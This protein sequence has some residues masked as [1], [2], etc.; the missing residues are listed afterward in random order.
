MVERQ[1]WRTVED[2]L[3]GL[4]APGRDEPR[5]EPEHPGESRR[6]FLK[7]MGFGVSAAALAGCT[8]IPERQAIPLLSQPEGLLPG[9]ES[10]YATTCGGCP[11]GCGVLAKVRDGRPIKIEGNPRSP[12]SQGATCAVGQA[13]V[14]SLYDEHRLRGPLLAGQPASWA[15]VD[16]WV[17]PRLAAIAE[18]AES[19][20]GLA[21]LTGTLV[22][23]S[24]RALAADFVR[25]F[26]NARHAVHDAVSLAALR[27][28]NRQSFGRP[29]IPH[30]RFDRARVIVGIEADFLG[31]WLS[32]VEHARAYAEGRRPESP[33]GMMRHYQFESGLSLTG[34]NADRRAGLLPSE[35]GLVALA[36]V[37]RVA[38]RAGATVAMVET[39]APDP[40]CD[41][42]LLDRVA[43]DLW[44][45]RGES[46]VVCGVN[47]P[48][49][50]VAVNHLNGLLGNV[51]RTVD[52]DNPSWQRQGD[53]GAVAALI[54]AMERG[55]V[56]GLLLWGVNPAYDHP[57]AERFVRALGNVALK[58]SLAETLDE[59]AALADAVCP[60]HNFLE[61]WGDA[62]PVAGHFGLRQPAIAPLFDTRAAHESLLRWQGEPADPRA[63]L[64]S[65]WQRELFP[66]QDRWPTFDDFWDHAL[67]EGGCE[68][69]PASG[70]PAA[71]PR[72]PGGL[73]AAAAAIVAESRRAQEV[74]SQGGYEV[75]LYEKVSLR[76]GR[77]ANNPWLQELPDPVSRITWGNYA[78][79]APSLALELALREGDVVA[80]RG[81][82]AA[83]ELPVH[84]QPGQPHHAISVA[85][86]YGRTRGGKA[87]TGVGANAFPFAK[88]RD[89]FVVAQ[90]TGV[91]LE[92]RGR[93]EDVATIQRHDLMEGRPIVREVALAELGRAAAPGHGEPQ[94][95]L[96][97]ER[98]RA[99]RSWGM[100]IDLSS[101]IGC[102]ACVVACQAENN[103]AV[104][105][106]DEVARG[107]E[108]HWI[109]ID[110][111]YSGPPEEPETVYQP[112][113]CQHC[114]NA[115][116][117]T[118]CPVLATVHS[119]DGLNQQVY[120][121]CIGTRY[122]ANNCPYKV[123]RFNWFEYAGND[124]FD[125]TMN[126]DLERM[127]LN[128]DVVVRSRGVMEKCSMCIQRI[129][130]GKLAAET[131]G[132]P[133]ADGAIR[134]ACQQACPTRAIV[135]G[136]LDDPVS[137][138]ALRRASPRSY[139]VLEELNTRPAVDY[140][141]RVRNR[142]GEEEA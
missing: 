130:A 47:D 7:L 75:R 43:A 34:S 24:S 89:G 16:A 3:P 87:G 39:A 100:A 127:V 70:E 122:C 45:H 71:A 20:A 51:G 121:R 124:R 74:R 21:L 136:D 66:R 93:R 12:L 107:R 41:P 101:C 105:G 117:E 90:A 116:C 17:A 102:A 95:S 9:V 114:A 115:P 8:R 131:R 32:P 138:V 133:L 68:L 110:R 97:A 120:N 77:H 72:D 11:A 112:M 76:D 126:G 40:P 132:E 46:L 134:T 104:V 22:S 78:C 50:Q 91:R 26:P 92:K 59:T 49:V 29:V 83:I 84:L 137:E 80:L 5:V 37:D 128:P 61:S 55:E 129:Q 30:F 140:L 113:M 64:R 111:Y 94:A 60:D 57:D 38:R 82:G 18:R 98:A 86:G 62:E 142:P 19:G 31:T 118:V 67:Q 4:E 109:R 27:E 25:R 10:W 103:V 99:S 106:R 28:A 36:L 6:D 123:R 139:R 88:L 79:V 63:H 33:A 42:A 141:A 35:L 44:Q 15:E 85:V 52:L 1:Y 23:P 119:S 56:H 53:D 58:V 13:T 135:F 125:Y 2:L 54:E 73:A 69:P 108:M 48:A 14:L 81:E 96:W 65:F